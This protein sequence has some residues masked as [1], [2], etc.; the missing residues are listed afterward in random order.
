MKMAGLFKAALRLAFDEGTLVVESADAESQLPPYFKWD[1]RVNKWRAEAFRYREILQWLHRWEPNCDLLRSDDG[2]RAFRSLSLQSALQ[3]EPR[4]YQAEALS[5][6]LKQER[7]GTIVLPTGAGKTYLALQAIETLRVSTLVIVPTLAL[8]AQWY[9]LLK[10]SFDVEI[11]LLGGGYHELRDLTVATYDSAYLYVHEFGNQFALLVFDEVH[12]LPAP[13][14][15]QIA[16]MSLAPYR[17]GLT[18]TYDS[19][20]LAG[21]DQLVGPLVYSRSPQ[22]LKGEYLA[23][24]V[25]VRMSVE[26]TLTERQEYQREYQLYRDYVTQHGLAIWK[27]WDWETFVKQS[28]YNEAARRALIAKQRAEEIALKAQKKM[29]VL[30]HLLKL[31]FVERVRPRVLIFTANNEFAYQISQEFLI[32]AITHQ[33]KTKERTS[34][35]QKFRTGKYAMLVSSHVLDE[36]ID[37]PEANVAIILSGSA[38]QREYIQRL[39]RILRKTPDGKLARLYEIIANDTLERH[40]SQRRRGAQSS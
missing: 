26:L 5:A 36:G 28:A 27:D 9:E 4:P 12:H 30:D 35:L 6:W 34:I 1:P 32:P 14:Y 13:T 31:H 11:G 20:N 17:L 16:R 39:G 21:L 25:I 24:Y 7:R 3:I 18:A 37:V 2:A 38:S 8:M 22:D 29:A 19:K 15:L 10:D 40:V 23:D 33:T